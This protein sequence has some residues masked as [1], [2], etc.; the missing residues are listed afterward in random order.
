MGRIHASGRVAAQGLD[1]DLEWTVVGDRI[2]DASENELE[3]WYSHRTASR[4]GESPGGTHWIAIAPGEFLENFQLA[5]RT[6]LSVQ[7]AVSS[8][9]RRQ[10]HRGLP[11]ALLW[12]TWCGVEAGVWPVRLPGVVVRDGRF[13]A[14][15][16]RDDPFDIGRRWRTLLAS[17]FCAIERRCPSVS[18]LACGQRV[19][20]VANL[21]DGGA[22]AQRHIEPGADPRWTLQARH[23]R[24]RHRHRRRERFRR[25]PAE[26]WIPMTGTSMASPYVAG[27]IGLMLAVEKTSP[28]T[29]KAS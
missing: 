16:E 28:G 15:I 22:A 25:D 6:M 19:I 13:H 26:P 2:N 4:S 1:V 21:D 24:A 10:L 5:D 9:E 12:A 11:V 18:A 3:L 27:V 17:F 29:P 14:W 23:R 7:R 8:R 20:A